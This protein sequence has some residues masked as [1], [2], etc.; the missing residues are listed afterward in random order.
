MEIDEIRKLLSEVAISHPKP[1]DGDELQALRKISLALAHLAEGIAEIR[2][3]QAVMIAHPRRLR[4]SPAR[5][6]SNQRVD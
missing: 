5:I 1:D 3:T 6:G 2:R 4:K